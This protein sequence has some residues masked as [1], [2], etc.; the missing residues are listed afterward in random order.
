[1]NLEG[2]A[3]GADTSRAGQ[4]DLDTEMKVNGAAQTGVTMVDRGLI[5]QSLNAGHLALE[6]HPCR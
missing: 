2:E 6:S 3:S 1:M 5:H 4:S